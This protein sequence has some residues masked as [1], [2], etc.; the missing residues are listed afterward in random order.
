[1]DVQCPYNELQLKIALIA[2]SDK[3][4]DVNLQ[5]KILSK[6]KETPNIT[7][8]KAI[9]NK[10]IADFNG[11]SVADLI[12]SPNYETLKSEYA[13]TLFYKIL[14]IYKDFNFTDKEAWALLCLSF[15]KL[16]V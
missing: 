16:S 9:F 10:N 6:I 14:N 15:G 7:E 4:A 13:S 3:L 8:D 2:A 5:E 12:N 11:I 1:M